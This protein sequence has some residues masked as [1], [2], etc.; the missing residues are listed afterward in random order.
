LIP[1]VIIR[2]PRTNPGRIALA[3]PLDDIPI[4]K[5][6]IECPFAHRVLAELSTQATLPREPF[7]TA[8]RAARLV[9]FSTGSQLK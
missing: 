9:K 6:K 5:Q 4:D 8:R 2:F 1:S 3:H 7:P